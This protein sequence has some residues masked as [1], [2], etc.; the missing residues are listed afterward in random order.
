MFEK[1]VYLRSLLIKNL[2]HVEYVNKLQKIIH[3]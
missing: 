3:N 2:N 1:L